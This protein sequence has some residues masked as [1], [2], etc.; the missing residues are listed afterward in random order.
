MSLA[1][2]TEKETINNIYKN[3]LYTILDSSQSNTQIYAD[4]SK[5]NSGVSLWN[6]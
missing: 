5:T 1:D 6:R 2:Y 3:V 4:A